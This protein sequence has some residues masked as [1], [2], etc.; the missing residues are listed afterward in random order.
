M[1]VRRRGSLRVVSLPRSAKRTPMPAHA[2]TFH[3]GAELLALP[4]PSVLCRPGRPEGDPYLRARE[5]SRSGRD[6]D[7]RPQV[8]KIVVD[9]AFG[10]RGPLCDD[11][12]PGWRRRLPRRCGCRTFT[13]PKESGWSRT[14][15][16]EPS[17]EQAENVRGQSIDVRDGVVRC[18][19]CHVTRSPGFPRPAARVRNRSRG[20]R[21]R[22]G[23]ERCHG[24]G[25]NHIA[26]S[27]A[28]FTDS[29]IVNAGSASAE[30]VIDRQ[31]ATA[32]PSAIAI[33]DPEPSRG[34]GLGPFARRDLTFSRCYK[35]SN[36]ALSCLTCHDP[37]RD[38]D[39]VVDALRGK[40]LSAIPPRLPCRQQ[41]TS[42]G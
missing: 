14:V 15:G 8:F 29:A 1:S 17:I 32:T 34:P 41:A 11:G 9:Y 35:E 33:R 26:A 22:I 28:G 16:N 21:R 18:V 5:G 30:A 7:R 31:C 19:Y 39:R 38:A 20:G 25:G 23:C 27:K 3:R 6:E 42:R 24:P 12:R 36:G 13:M 10:I 37:H 40:C 4:F 2:R